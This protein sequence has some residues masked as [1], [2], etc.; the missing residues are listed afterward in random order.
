MAAVLAGGPGAVLSH[1]SAAKLWGIRA[2]GCSRA[3]ITVPLGRRA[4]SGVEVHHGA[5]AEDERTS[6]CGIPVTTA[7][8]TLLDL[9]AVF[10]PQRLE[11]ALREAEFR[12]LGDPTSLVALLERHPRRRGT[13]ILRRMLAAGRLGDGVTRSVLEDRFLAFLDD[14]GLPR[15]KLNRH[16]EVAGRL[17]ECDCVWRD[18]RVIVEL[19]GH[20]AHG[21][22]SAFEEDRARD[23]TLNAAGWRIVRVTWRQLERE[24]DALARDMRRLLTDAS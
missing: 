8:R 1:R 4:G 6:L 18:E 7:S 2:S 13:A 23:R 20:A 10:D 11:R 3:E 24:E 12:R 17:V 5:L 14:R 9:A 21:R 16:V 15:P 19:D 22:R